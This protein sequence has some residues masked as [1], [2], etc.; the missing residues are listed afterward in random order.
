MSIYFSLEPEQLWFEKMMTNIPNFAPRYC[1]VRVYVTED[2]PFRAM[3]DEMLWNTMSSIR[4]LAFRKRFN[5]H[6]KE[7]KENTMS[8]RGDR[9][10][11][12][13][14]KELQKR[15]NPSAAMLCVLY[16]LTAD[17]RL[18][19]RLRQNIYA[20]GV[21][22]KNVHLGDITP[23]AY[24]LFLAAKDLYYGT[25]HITISDLADKG[26]ISPQIFGIVCEAMAIRRYGLTVCAA[27]AGRQ[28]RE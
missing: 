9:H 23:E 12:L 28:G 14:C 19:S 6:L 17:S 27:A 5:A 22:L 2:V 7:R 26:T 16:L 25:K 18:W 24:T 4:N 10:Q 20:K 15:E 8:Y 11:A 21:Q 13:F 1:D 3:H